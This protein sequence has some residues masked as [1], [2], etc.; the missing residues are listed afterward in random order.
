MECT[1]LKNAAGAE[2]LVR[3]S[4]KI[5]IA[6]QK[7]KAAGNR[8]TCSLCR[9][10]ANWE[11]C[12]SCGEVLCREGHISEH[13]SKKSHRLFINTRNG[14]IFCEGCNYFCRIR[15]VNEVASILWRETQG[16][17]Q[18]GC[19]P[20]EGIEESFEKIEAECVKGFINIKKTCYLTSLLQSLV[21]VPLFTRRILETEH[22]RSFCSVENCFVCPLNNI[23]YQVGSSSTRVVDTSLFVNRFWKEFPSFSRGR[24]QDVQEAFLY[25]GNKM[26]TDSEKRR[27]RGK[28]S[29]PFHETFGGSCTSLIRCV[30]CG[31]KHS[32][33]EPF[34][35]LSLDLNRETLKEMVRDYTREEEIHL[36]KA[37]SRC[38]LFGPYTKQLQM[39]ELPE[40]LSIH[41]KRYSVS[42]DGQ[43]VVKRDDFISCEERVE[44]NRQPYVLHSAI[45]HVG[46]MDLGHYTSFIQTGGRWFVVNDESVEEDSFPTEKIGK[47]AYLLFYRRA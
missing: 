38:G 41:L 42:E 20:R 8:I 24:H 7:E 17:P 39:E 44:F 33:S 26:H 15:E 36:E 2:S 19:R 6:R 43:R 1:H 40:V 4:I 18:P 16:V 27:E 12:L 34:T 47:T 35:T 31:S 23:I 3:R 5:L 14:H 9:E 30:S 29:C 22:K 13:S 28:C 25:L 37:C 46:E 10:Q 11:V 45:S 21:N 32:S